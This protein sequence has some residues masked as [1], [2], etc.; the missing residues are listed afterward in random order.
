MIMS[1]DASRFPLHF[2]QKVLGCSVSL[3]QGI[4]ISIGW[5]ITSINNTNR[6]KLGL[7]YTNS[8]VKVKLY[9]TLVFFVGVSSLRVVE[10]STH[11]YSFSCQVYFTNKLVLVGTRE[12]PR[13]VVYTHWGRL[14]AVVPKPRLFWGCGAA[15]LP[16]TLQDYSVLELRSFAIA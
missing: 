6:N 9:C 12:W 4:Y 16:H 13:G 14:E 7:R 11:C 5:C 15:S 10:L 8:K 3:I 2:Q 1:K